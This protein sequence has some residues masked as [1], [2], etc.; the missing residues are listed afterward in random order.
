MTL[1]H[2]TFSLKDKNDKYVYCVFHR[3]YGLIQINYIVYFQPITRNKLSLNFLSI[4]KRTE[5]IEFAVVI[6][7]L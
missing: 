6:F 2:L 4:I 5:T 3:L 7:K 1:A